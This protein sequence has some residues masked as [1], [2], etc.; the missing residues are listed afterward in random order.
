LDFGFYKLVL[1]QSLKPNHEVS[2]TFQQRFQ[3]TEFSTELNP[4]LL[5]NGTLIENYQFPSIGYMDD[6]EITDQTFRNDYNLGEKHKTALL[7]DP[8][9]AKIGKADGDGE[10][11]NFDLM[12]S[13]DTSQIAV[14]P[15]ELLGNWTIDDRNYF[16]YSSE[17]KITNLYCIVSADYE[18]VS[19][20]IALSN[21]SDSTKN[22]DL[23]IYYH[24]GHEFNLEH[25]MQGMETSLKYFSEKYSPFQF[26]D[27]RITEVPIYH[28]RAQ[29]LP[30]LITKAENM[31]FTFDI[32]DEDTP[33]LPFFITAHEVSHQWWG[34]QVNP[35]NVQGQTMLSEMLAQYSA[36]SVYK[37]TFPKE[38]V[39]ELLKWNMR[40]YFKQ[41]LQEEVEEM[42]LY[43]VES[44]QDYIHYRKGLIVMHSFQ[45][46]V[47][48]EKINGALSE[49]IADWNSFNGTRYFQENRYPKS[50]D[51]LEYFYAITPDSFM[52]Q[53][54][55]LFEEVIIYDNRIENAQVEELSKTEFSIEIQLHLN[56]SR[57]LGLES[58][59]EIEFTR[60]VEIG[61]YQ[62]D[63]EG[64]EKLVEL[65]E[66]TIDPTNNVY[67]FNLSVQPDFV[68]LDPHLTLL[69][70]NIFDNK[71]KVN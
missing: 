38:H 16:H 14:A 60:P 52:N 9:F 40:Q 13:T 68:K 7:D 36:L 39:D 47:S 48:E 35:A 26:S 24:A 58:E 44:G 51:L 23:E 19:S 71:R 45:K 42:P 37:Q 11:I 10:Y 1:D 31:G 66:I 2:I 8:Q 64:N 65:R 43:L 59:E 12:V 15:G 4:N 3:S 5:K 62:L 50:T 30:G 49:F 28:D 6:I 29:S 57:V 69:D 54:K 46:M 56:K 22:V 53:A 32:S 63:D 25:I 20:S 18:S 67:T 21:N 27:L 41:R 33:N 34:D 70:K 61:F 55:E 17:E